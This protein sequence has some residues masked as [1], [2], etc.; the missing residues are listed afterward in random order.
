M[1]KFTMENGFKIKGMA[2]VNKL[3]HM[4]VFMK[5]NGY[6]IKDMAKVKKHLLMV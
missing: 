3:Y 2:E 4:V 6:K 5:E 1:V